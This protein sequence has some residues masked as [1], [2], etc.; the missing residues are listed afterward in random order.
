MIGR[1]VLFIPTII[2]HIFFSRHYFFKKIF[3]FPTFPPNI[4]ANFSYCFT[5]GKVHRSYN[6]KRKALERIKA[7]RRERKKE[8]REPLSRHDKNGKL[9]FG[10]K[11]VPIDMACA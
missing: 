11:A 7:K 1:S 10:G 8:T 5:I 4:F 3:S 2:F 9:W 6:S